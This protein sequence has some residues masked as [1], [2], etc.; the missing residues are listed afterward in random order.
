MFKNPFIHSYLIENGNLQ[1]TNNLQTPTD[2]SHTIY[3]VFKIVAGKPLFIED[4]LQRLSQSVS[5]M[6]LQYSVNFQM[7]KNDVAELCKANDVYFG[8][9]E[10]MLCFDADNSA[11]YY[12]GFI[13]H[14]Y[15]NPTLYLQGIETQTVSVVRDNPNV[16]IKNTASRKQADK[17]I[18]ETAVYEVLL[19]NSQNQ[20]TEGSRSNLFF[21]KNDTFYTAPDN[22]VLQG[23][24]RLKTIELIQKQNWK[25]IFNPLLVSE[26]EECDSAF[27]CGTSP[28]ILP[29]SKINNIKFDVQNNFLRKLMLYYN[30]MVS[31]YCSK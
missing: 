12:L 3:E 8:N 22:L 27:I 16:K 9:M 4:H 5:K 31:D 17:H 11:K 20:L 2:I 21:I 14:K 24:T 25:L 30:D 26:I 7:I 13:P 18:K 6:G 28:G 19:A 29:I 15:P 23:I 10:L 1:Q